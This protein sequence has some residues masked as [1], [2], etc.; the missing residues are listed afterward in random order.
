VLNVSGIGTEMKET[1]SLAFSTVD[2]PMTKILSATVTNE[3]AT[4]STITAPTITGTGAAEYSVLPYN[5]TNSTCLN[6]TVVLTMSQHCTLTV[7]FTPPSPN[8]GTNFTADLNINS[9][10]G[11]PIVVAISGKN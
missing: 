4:S 11:G 8:N 3:G 7:Q 10:G 9:T 6:G 1:G 2:N 5:G